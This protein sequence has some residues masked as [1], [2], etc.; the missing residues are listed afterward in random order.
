VKSLPLLCQSTDLYRGP[1]VPTVGLRGHVSAEGLTDVDV[2]EIVGVRPDKSVEFLGQLT[3]EIT[4]VIFDPT[5]FQYVRAI[6]AYSS[7]SP[8]D[9][10]VE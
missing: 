7:G 9:V 5:R 1:Y 6:R 4:A 3:I 2:M 10:W 8:V